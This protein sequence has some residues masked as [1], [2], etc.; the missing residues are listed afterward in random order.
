MFLLNNSKS[1]KKYAIWI[2]GCCEG[3]AAGNKAWNEHLRCSVGPKFCFGFGIGNRNQGPI[4]V[5]EP[6]FFSLLLEE[7]K[8]LWAG[9]WAWKLT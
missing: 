4:S 2:T 7:Y 8:F 6:N 5:S 9:L 1:I 3:S